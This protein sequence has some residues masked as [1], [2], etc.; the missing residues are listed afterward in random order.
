MQLGRRVALAFNKGIDDVFGCTEL[1]PA[2]L[3]RLVRAPALRWVRVS[4]GLVDDGTRKALEAR[5]CVVVG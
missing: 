1:T 4:E 3:A 2:G 5:D